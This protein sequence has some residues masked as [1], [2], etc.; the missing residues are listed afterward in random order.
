MADSWQFTHNYFKECL[1]SLPRPCGAE[2]LQTMPVLV[3]SLAPKI[4]KTPISHVVVERRWQEDGASTRLGDDNND[5]E[6][7][8]VAGSRFGR[9]KRVRY[10]L[11]PHPTT[12]FPAPTIRESNKTS[13]TLALDAKLFQKCPYPRH[14]DERH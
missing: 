13:A 8:G 6:L 3:K 9:P 10:G 11:R 5:H 12:R 14:R 1:L 2:T 4:P 7:G